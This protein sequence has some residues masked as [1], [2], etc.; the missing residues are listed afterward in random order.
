MAQTTQRIANWA[1][2]SPEWTYNAGLNYGHDCG[3]GKLGFSG[4]LFYSSRVYFDPQDRI[5][6]DS[7]VRRRGELTATAVVWGRRVV[8]VLKRTI[9][10]STRAGVAIDEFL[11][12][13]M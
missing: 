2:R 11:N 5:S 9:A 7:Y 6:Q 3:F 1:I 8:L 10:C 12:P 13:A 4:N